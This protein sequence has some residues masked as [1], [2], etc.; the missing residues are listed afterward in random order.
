MTNKEELKIKLKELI[1]EYNQ[2]DEDFKK[3]MSEDDTRA[4]FIDPLLKIV[5]GWEERDIDRQKS[6]EA[7][8][9]EGHM[10]RADT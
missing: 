3:N 8:T 6:I 5:L 7:L 10:K 9:P 1:D 2:Y 4:K